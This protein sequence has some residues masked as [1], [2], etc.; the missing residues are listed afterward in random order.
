M[1]NTKA[2][3]KRNEELAKDLATAPVEVEE[4]GVSPHPRRIAKAKYQR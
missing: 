3:A 2:I 4:P 1:G